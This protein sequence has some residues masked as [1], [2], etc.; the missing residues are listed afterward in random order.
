MNKKKMNIQIIAEILISKI[1]QLVKYVKLLM[2]FTDEFD[3]RLE[4]IKNTEVKLDTSAAELVVERFEKLSRKR[5]YFPNW[6]IVTIICIFFTTIISVF[7]A[8]FE[9]EKRF[10]FQKRA[11]IYEEYLREHNQVEQYNE[12][13]IQRENSLKFEPSATKK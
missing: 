3:E 10:F 4:Q 2:S 6:L 7:F 13:I 1:E 12:W 9:L 8:S 5:I 11:F